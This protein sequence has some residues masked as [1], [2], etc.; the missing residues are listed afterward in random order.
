MYFDP[1][2]LYLYIGC[3]P[4]F[5]VGPVVSMDGHDLK[6]GT[7]RYGIEGLRD[8]VN[9][10]R[11]QPQSQNILIACA[12]GH[13]SDPACRITQKTPGACKPSGSKIELCNLTPEQAREA[14]R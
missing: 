11:F 12:A 8:F 1:D 4:A 3:R 9:E 7:A 6:V 2:I 13:S 14:L 10:P 5:M